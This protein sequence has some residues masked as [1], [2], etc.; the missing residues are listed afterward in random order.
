VVICLIKSTPLL[1]LSIVLL[2]LLAFGENTGGQE[3]GMSRIHGLHFIWMV[4]DRKSALLKIAAVFG[5]E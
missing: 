3:I 2:L 5:D 1:T 4:V